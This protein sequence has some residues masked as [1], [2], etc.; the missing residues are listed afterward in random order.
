MNEHRVETSVRKARDGRARVLSEDARSRRKAAFAQAPVDDGRPFEADL[1][2]DDANVRR[3]LQALE[4]EAP[5]SGT[6]FELD[7][8]SLALN[9]GAGIDDFAFGQARCIGGVGVVL[10][11]R[12]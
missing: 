4:N 5:A 6:N 11:E 10:H 12:G 3:C 1:E 8:A 2:P 9:E 7:G